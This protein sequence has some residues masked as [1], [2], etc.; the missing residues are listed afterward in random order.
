MKKHTTH[1]KNN[2]QN[3][4]SKGRGSLRV[5]RNLGLGVLL[6]GLF[7]AS[8][9][10]VKCGYY[11]LCEIEMIT[12]YIRHDV[13]IL[14]PKGAIQ[15]EVAD[16]KGERE[17]GLSGRVS[18]RNDEGILFVFETPGKYG[19]WMKDMNFPLDIIWINENGLVVDI[20]RDLSPDSYPKTFINEVDASYVL[21]VNAGLAKEF[22]LFL[23][24]KVKIT[25]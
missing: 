25:D 9:Y 3:P 21:E 23:G 1:N 12:K 13:T 16:S 8:M 22:G 6:V 4:S 18:M 7:F 17:Q 20:E 10:G 15:V 11:K 5:V 19:F 2:T 14:M 24:S